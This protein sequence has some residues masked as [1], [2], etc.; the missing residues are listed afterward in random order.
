VGQRDR[1]SLDALGL[2]QFI[3]TP[4]RSRCVT[5]V[6]AEADAPSRARSVDPQ[7]Q[8]MDRAEHDERRRVVTR[9]GE[10]PGAEFDL[11]ELA[12]DRGAHRPALDLGLYGADLGVG[13]RHRPPCFLETCRD[14]LD[15]M[16]VTAQLLGAD[17]Q[18]FWT[19]SANP[20]PDRP[21]RRPRRKASPA[22]R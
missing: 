21:R 10:F 9:K 18:K 15:G 16:P 11:Q 1:A 8:R 7:V 19:R 6:P 14:G 5:S 4:A 3:K 17:G 12:G 22:A 2:A 20:R 13:D